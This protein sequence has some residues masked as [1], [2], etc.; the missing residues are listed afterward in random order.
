MRVEPTV[1]SAEQ[2]ALS[3]WQPW[4]Y[5]LVTGVKDV[6]NRTWRTNH[7]SRLWIHASQRF[8]QEAYRALRAAGVDLPEPD[9][10]P[11]R[12]ASRRNRAHRLCARLAERMGGARPVA[13]ADGPALGT[14]ATDPD[15]RPTAAV[16]GQ[17]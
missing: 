11:A 1:R 14:A 8:D 4:A 7:R 13:L 6:E 2:M 5:L 15:A 10:L 17:S 3:V 16:P 12:R 9:R